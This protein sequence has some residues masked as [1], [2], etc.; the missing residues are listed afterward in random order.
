M[1]RHRGLLLHP[2]IAWLA[3]RWSLPKRRYCLRCPVKRGSRSA[4]GTVLTS[5]AVNFGEAFH[6][7]AIHWLIISLRISN[8][9]RRFCGRL[10][11][12]RII[13]ALASL[14]NTTCP[15]STSKIEFKST[16]SPQTDP[17]LPCRSSIDCTYASR[18]RIPLA[19]ETFMLGT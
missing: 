1:W 6:S 3:G 14:L 17:P 8:A 2:W 9:G 12:H 16:P 10:V 19:V 13:R 18:S 5:R 7:L 15:A 11:R 4:P